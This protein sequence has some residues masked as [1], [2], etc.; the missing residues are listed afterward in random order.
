MSQ[1]RA[2]SGG[3]GSVWE[4]VVRSERGCFGRRIS[5]FCG[6]AGMM[7]VLAGTLWFE[8]CFFLLLHVN[9]SDG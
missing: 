7:F 1:G 8:F 3:L 5:G 6:G 4:S 2:R 9:V